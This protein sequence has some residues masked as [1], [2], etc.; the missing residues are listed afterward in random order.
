[1]KYKVEDCVKFFVDVSRLN[2]VIGEIIEVIENEDS[3]M[4]LYEGSKFRVHK[5]FVTEKIP[6][7]PDTTDMITSRMLY[8]K[9][10][11]EKLKKIIEN[12]REEILRLKQEKYGVFGT[13]IELIRPPGPRCYNCGS[14]NMED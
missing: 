5:L 8:Y 1:M 10:E 3:Y 7:G 13:H 4:I 6:R 9:N 14:G 12:Q 2:P 11:T